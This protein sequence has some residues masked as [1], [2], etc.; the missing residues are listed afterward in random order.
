M[1][2]L[3]NPYQ[4]DLT[5]LSSQVEAEQ[6]RV[7]NHFRNYESSSNEEGIFWEIISFHYHHL[8][9]VQEKGLALQSAPKAILMDSLQFIRLQLGI[10]FHQIAHKLSEP[11]NQNF[12][13]ILNPIAMIE[14]L[15]LTKT[16]A[17]FRHISTHHLIEAL[18]NGR[19]IEILMNGSF[20]NEHYAKMGIFNEGQS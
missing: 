15:T 8:H 18:L 7:L 16:S 11:L 19:C 10:Y 4:F 6:E 9:H 17:A 1:Q 2:D 3:S 20:S 12:K 14:L 5:L 13:F